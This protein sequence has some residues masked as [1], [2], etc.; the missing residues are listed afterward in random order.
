MRLVIQAFSGSVA[1]I[2]LAKEAAEHAFDCLARVAGA[3]HLF[4]NRHGLIGMIPEDDIPRAMLESVSLI[5]DDDLTPVAAVAGTIADF[6]ADW[7]FDRRVTRVIVGGKF[8]LTPD[9]AKIVGQLQNH[10][11]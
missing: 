4:K 1:E 2:E 5:G 10:L 6:V 7:L 9:F 8:A 3:Q 11:P